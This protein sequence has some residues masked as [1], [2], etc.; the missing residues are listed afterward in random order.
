MPEIAHQTPTVQ[1]DSDKRGSGRWFRGSRAYRCLRVMI[2]LDDSFATS[3]PDDLE[4]WALTNG[5]SKERI[6][7]FRKCSWWP[8]KAYRFALR[9]SVRRY[10][11]LEVAAF[12]DDADL[13]A[14]PEP[15]DSASDKEIEYLLND[16]AFVAM[17][18][19]TRKEMVKDPRRAGAGSSVGFE[20]G[21]LVAAVA[22]GLVA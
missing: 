16:P 11:L 5:L 21:G 2:Y 1:L 6:Q 8:G 14:D 13:Q 18:N 4:R 10:A 9:E 3:Q 19:G 12:K 22:K 17:V 20:A 15:E 7:Q